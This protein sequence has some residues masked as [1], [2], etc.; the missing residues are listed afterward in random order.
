MSVHTLIYVDL[1]EEKL[2]T[3]QEWWEEVGGK[4]FLSDADIDNAYRAYRLAFQPWRIL[5]KSGDNY[6][7]MFRS[8]ERYFNEA[9]ARHA[10]EITFGSESNVYLRQAEHGNVALRMAAS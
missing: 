8:T 10:A 5:V 4:E 9:D 2:L 7:A 6:K 3:R 1:I